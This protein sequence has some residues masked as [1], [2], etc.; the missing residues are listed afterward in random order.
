MATASGRPAVIAVTQ[1]LN[2]HIILVLGLEFKS[3]VKFRFI[4]RTDMIQKGIEQTP[5]LKQTLESAVS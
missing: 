1:K 2:S 4:E 3:L 5:K